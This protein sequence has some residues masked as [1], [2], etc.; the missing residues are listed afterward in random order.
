MNDDAFAAMNRAAYYRDKAISREFIIRKFSDIG[1]CGGVWSGYTM[2]VSVLDQFPLVAMHN[3]IYH[4]YFKRFV[5]FF[6]W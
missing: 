1:I 3:A 6:C 5:L 2:T 4:V